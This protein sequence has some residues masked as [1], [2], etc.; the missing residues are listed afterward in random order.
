MARIRRGGYVFVTWIGDHAPRRVHV[1]GD[2]GLVLKWDLE[3][4]V[5]MEGVPVKRV[6]DLIRELQREGRL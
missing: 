6:L 2:R 4:E 3:H 5:P 1:Y